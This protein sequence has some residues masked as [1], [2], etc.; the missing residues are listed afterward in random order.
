MAV[1]I[2]NKS[3]QY[4][5]VDNEVKKMRKCESQ[6]GCFKKTKQARFLEN[7]HVLPPNMNTYACVSGA[8]KCLF[9]INFVVPSF[10][11]KPI[12][13]CALLPYYPQIMTLQCLSYISVV[14]N[15]M[16]ISPIHL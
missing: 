5:F 1:T 8:K 4:K 9:F 10:L 6:N 14:R 11:E 12:L 15:V 16:Q 7:K 3:L 2:V 13:R